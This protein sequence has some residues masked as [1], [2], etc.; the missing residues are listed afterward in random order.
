MAVNQP[1]LTTKSN[2]VACDHAAVCPLKEA[3]H[4]GTSHDHDDTNC[5]DIFCFGIVN[6]T[7]QCV[8]TN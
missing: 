5:C 6:D 3:C 2:L 7:V 1:E 4:H 8:S